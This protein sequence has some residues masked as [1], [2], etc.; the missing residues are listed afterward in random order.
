VALTLAAAATVRSG[1]RLVYSVCTLTGAETTGVAARVLDQLPG[2]TALPPPTG[3]RAHG[4][5]ALVLPQDAG[6]D[7]MFVL[8]LERA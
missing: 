5:G 1:G 2:F 6:T 8:T 7:G 3:W 4:P